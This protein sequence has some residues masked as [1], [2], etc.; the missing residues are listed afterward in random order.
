MM[1]STNN[2]TFVKR[3]GLKGVTALE[4]LLHFTLILNTNDFTS[5]RRDKYRDRYLN[6]VI[7]I[8]V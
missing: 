4:D 6:F 2:F 8:K 1:G 5:L 3:L 7:R